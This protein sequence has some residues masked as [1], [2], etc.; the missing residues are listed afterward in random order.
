MLAT[1]ALTLAQDREMWRAV[2]MAC[3]LGA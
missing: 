1:D 3:G 2:T